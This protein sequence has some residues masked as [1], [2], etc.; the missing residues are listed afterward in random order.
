MWKSNDMMSGFEVTY[1]L[2]DIPGD[3]GWHKITH[4]FGTADL[5][6]EY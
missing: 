3:T 6:S 5:N 1:E 4:M 2:E